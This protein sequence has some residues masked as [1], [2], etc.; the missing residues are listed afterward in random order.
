MNLNLIQN[1]MI[2]DFVSKLGFKDTLSI[3]EQ[4]PL[5]CHLTD[6]VDDIDILQCFTDLV[7][8]IN[9][10]KHDTFCKRGYDWIV[11]TNFLS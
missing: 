10:L 2:R 5:A 6:G 4:S 9:G 7:V 3:V 8:Y 1:E 11:G